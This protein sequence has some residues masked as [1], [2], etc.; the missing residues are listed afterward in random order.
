MRYF[1]WLGKIIYL[2]VR[3]KVSPEQS[4]KNLKIDHNKPVCYIFNTR[5]I[6][7]LL[8]L[9]YHCK[10]EGLPRPMYTLSSLPGSSRATCVYLAK[11][12]IFQQEV[13]DSEPAPLHTL[14]DLVQKEDSDVQLVPVSVFWGRNP[15]KG[16]K[17][18]FKLL[19]FDD[20]TGGILQRFFTFFVQG[21]D[22]FCLL[23]QPISA[24]NFLE[25]E[26][27]LSKAVKKLKRVLGIHFRRQRVGVLGPN[28]Y[29]R[30][31]VINSL[32]RSKSVQEAI[33]QEA[34]RKNVSILKTR[35][36]AKKYIDEVAAN[37]SYPVV[38]FF[39]LLFS[40]IWKRI[41][42]KIVVLNSEDLKDLAGENELIF[43][44]CHRSHM[45]YLLVGHTLYSQ[46][47]TPAHTAAGVNLNFWPVGS[48]LRRGGAFFIRRTFAA[49]RLYKVIFTEYVHFL[50][51]EGYSMSFYIEGGRSRTGR[52]LKPKNGLLSMVMKSAERKPSQSMVIIPVY[53]G[54]DK[55]LEGLSYLKELSGK[56]KEQESVTQLIKARKVLKAKVGK[57]YLNF[58]K[59][60]YIRDYLNKTDPENLEN[61][62]SNQLS[63]DVMCQINS[64]AVVSPVSLFSLILLSA[65]NKALNQEDLLNM[66]EKVYLLFQQCKYS[67][68][69]SLPEDPV[70]QQLLYAES[71]APITRFHHPGGDVLY[72]DEKDTVLLSYYKNNIL[73]LIAVPSLICSFFEYKD[74][75]S[76]TELVSSCRY[77]YKFLR[78]DLFIHWHADEIE[79]VIEA[80]I[81]Q[82][83]KIGLLVKD[84]QNED[85]IQRPDLMS[86][87]F[88]YLKVFGLFLG[89][90]IQRYAIF[91]NLLVRYYNSSQIVKI[92]DFE[93]ECLL[94]SKRMSVLGGVKESNIFDHKLFKSF[95]EQLSNNQD[96]SVDGKN[97]II[98]KSLAVLADKSLE[99]L[100]LDVRQTVTRSTQVKE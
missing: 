84:A 51:S 44:P 50:L 72:V 26:E 11:S 69:I 35:N 25:N 60:I 96:I 80:N 17:S 27:D 79:K 19:F 12:G 21:R 8:V 16:E 56:A 97:I 1:W 36:I 22:V 61:L 100:S 41:Y 15:G 54:Y 13:G 67:A 90:T 85:M 32:L 87:E 91:S 66:A 57:A 49:N 73:H 77:M 39:A 76:F 43:L 30:D 59:P 78:E 94:L 6:T 83:I 47:M 75:L 62:S 82:L 70:H 52:L 33:E 95:I 58:G 92:K 29:D 4:Y 38:R 5:S 93:N 55:M 98:H 7:D 63:F 34:K 24:Q 74:S 99:L 86:Q 40:W 88:Y 9:D 46:G 20:E 2:W 81:S 10:K 65:P 53:V 28:I 45:D 18:L 71:L 89:D 64:A 23:G 48:L 3:S 31:L 42:T 37:M 14:L 68:R